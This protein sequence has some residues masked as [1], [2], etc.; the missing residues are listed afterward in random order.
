MSVA[1]AYRGHLNRGRAL[2]P[3]AAR[4]TIKANEESDRFPRAPDAGITLQ[5]L[6]EGIFNPDQDAYITLSRNTGI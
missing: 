4:E 5:H 2:A 1:P 6:D 3:I